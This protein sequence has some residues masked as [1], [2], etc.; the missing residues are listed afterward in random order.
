MRDAEKLSACTLAGHGKHL[1]NLFK[2]RTGFSREMSWKL[3]VKV[4]VLRMGHRPTRD[5]RVTTH[6]GLVARAFGA[7]GIILEEHVERS[8][9]E[10]LRE[11]TLR[12]GGPFNVST[13]SSPRSEVLK[14]KKSG[15]LVVH[16]TMYGLNIQ[17]TNVVDRIRRAS[18]PILVVVGGA[19]VPRWVYD[20]ADYNVA[21]GNQPHSEVAALAVFL[22][23]LFQGEEL[24]RDFRDAAIKVIP[25]ERDK[26]VRKVDSEQ[27][28]GS[29]SNT[30]QEDTRTTSRKNSRDSKEKG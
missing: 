12:W 14:W 20:E 27:R 26:I 16:L 25:S 3:G 28:R 29:N 5:H 22:D 15:G 21:I 23:R 1:L 9:L 11:T 7:D 18:K 8:I 6:V 10:T 24:L 4:Y 17:E 13:T 30:C 19:K 2:H